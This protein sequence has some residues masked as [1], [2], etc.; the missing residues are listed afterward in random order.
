[1]CM[2]KY[3]AISLLAVFIV[4][5]VAFA[6]WWNPFTWK[7]FHKKEMVTQ[8]KPEVQNPEEKINELQK[9]LEDL[10]TQQTQVITQNKIE[11]IKSGNTITKNIKQSTEIIDVCFNIEGVQLQVP[12]GYFS[13]SGICTLVDI[14][15]ICPNIDG[16]QSKIPEGKFL[17]KNTNQCLTENEIIDIEEIIDIKESENKLDRDDILSRLAKI[18]GFNNYYSSLSTEELSKLLKLE[19]DKEY[20]IILNELYKIGITEYYNSGLSIDELENILDLEKE[21]QSIEKE[22]QNCLNSYSVGFDYVWDSNACKKNL[23]SDYYIGCSGG[24]IKGFRPSNL[25]CG[26]ASA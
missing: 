15:D 13:T 22:R 7:I 19:E 6:S 20:N 26:G 5:S 3:I 4:P 9:Q 25:T 2:K 18:N 21:K 23:K 8:I 17:Y 12:S 11:P 1:M 10:K 16:V 14:K 24:A